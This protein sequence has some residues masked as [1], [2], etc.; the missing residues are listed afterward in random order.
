MENQNTIVWYISYIWFFLDRVVLIWVKFKTCYTILKCAK[1]LVEETIH[2]NVWGVTLGA[3]SMELAMHVWFDISDWVIC[4]VMRETIIAWLISW[5]LR[6][7]S[8]FR[9]FESVIFSFKIKSWTTSRSTTW[10]IFTD[11]KGIFVWSLRTVSTFASFSFIVFV[12]DNY[13]SVIVLVR[14]FTKW[15]YDS[16]FIWVVRF[17]VFYL[18]QNYILFRL[19]ANT[20]KANLIFRVKWLGFVCKNIY[21]TFSVLGHLT[22][23][24][25]LMTKFLH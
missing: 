23:I 11:H 3:L 15:R 22:R 24:L 9:S 8:R 5:T 14:H 1:W 21:Y 18:I 2:F 13:S 25:I 17:F 6:L 7:L 19:L 12:A 10:P 20:K 4:I 16:R